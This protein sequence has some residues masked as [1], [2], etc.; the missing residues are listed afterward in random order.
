MYQ[1]EVFI[2]SNDVD[3]LNIFQEHI[4]YA[5][6][7]QLLAKFPVIQHVLFGSILEFKKITPGTILSTARLGMLPPR[8]TTATTPTAPKLSL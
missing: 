2:P 1:K 7:F 8:R 3:E 4:F 6:S 5:F